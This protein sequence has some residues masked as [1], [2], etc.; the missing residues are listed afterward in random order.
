MSKFM[1]IMAIGARGAEVGRIG[2]DSDGE[3]VDV[4]NGEASLIQE[5]AYVVNFDVICCC[6]RA[7]VFVFRRF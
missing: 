2:V 3:T 1:T 7:I 4:S 6:V 5:S